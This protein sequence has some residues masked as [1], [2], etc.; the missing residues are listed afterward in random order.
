ME[1]RP[2]VIAGLLAVFNALLI[3]ACGPRAVTPSSNVDKAVGALVRTNGSDGGPGT[4]AQPSSE[5]IPVAASDAVRG[6]ALAPV[7]IV[8]F[9]GLECPFSR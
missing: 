9:F 1:A 2:A 5:Q 7:T 8:G 4:I 6:S 3:A